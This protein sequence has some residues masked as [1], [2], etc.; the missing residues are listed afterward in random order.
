M[1]GART[2]LGNHSSLLGALEALIRK[3]TANDSVSGLWQLALFMALLLP[4]ALGVQTEPLF[5]T[6]DGTKE[7]ATDPP[8]L[9]AA[10]LGFP[11]AWAGSARKGL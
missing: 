7:G 9:W 4:W 5:V 2:R 6:E 3:E 11:A 8:S 10:G 1:W